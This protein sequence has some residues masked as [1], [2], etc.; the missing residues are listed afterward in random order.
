MS[1]H[2]DRAE[3]EVRLWQEIE[4]ARFGM[5]GLVGGPARHLQ[6]MTAFA[7][8]AEGALWF[9]TKRTNDLVLQSGSGHAALFCVVSKDQEFQACLGGT[10]VE[11]PDLDKIKEFWNPVA[12][13]WFP[14]GQNDPELTLLRFTPEDAQVWISRSGP[15]GFAWEIAKANLTHTEPDVGDKAHLSLL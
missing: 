4:K 10:L 12:A 9:Y 13:A 3:T 14:D 8:K 6:P 1:T 15:L 2:L 7:D 5:L 11:D